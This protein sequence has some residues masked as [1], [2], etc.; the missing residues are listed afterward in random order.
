MERDQ[1]NLLK[2]LPIADYLAYRGYNPVYRTGQRLRYYSPIRQEDTPSFWVDQ[3][4]NRYKDFGSNDKGDDLL[5]LIMRLDNCSFHTA[6]ATLQH[7]A[8]QDDKPCFSFIG[9]S[10]LTAA[11][12]TAPRSVKLLSNRS[13]MRYVSHRRISYPIAR[14]YLQEVYYQHQDMNYFALGFANDKGGYVLRSAI[15]KRNLGQT[16][17]TTLTVPGSTAVNL[18]EG[19]FDFLSALEY[20]KLSS[21]RCTTI[22]LNSTTNLEQALPTLSA[23]QRVNTYLDNDKAGRAAFTALQQAGVICIDRAG[24]YTCYND[25]NAFWMARQSVDSLDCH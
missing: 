9:I 14:R 17:V 4:L 10:P 8:G 20:Y 21:P 13:L 16:G 1:I 6:L 12:T 23:A 3:V 18:F 24:L 22:V 19:V 15:G 5:Q 7:Y 11:T 25:F 2:Q